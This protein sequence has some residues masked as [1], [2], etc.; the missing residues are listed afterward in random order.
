MFGP[1]FVIK[2]M[3]CPFQFGSHL[4]REEKAGCFTIILFLLP[5]VCICGRLGSMSLPRGTMIWSVS[6][7]NGIFPGH[8][9]FF[10][11]V[12]V[13]V[14][15]V[16]LLLFLLCVFCWV[17]RGVTSTAAPAANFSN[18]IGFWLLPGK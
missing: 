17:G 14:V 2:K 15:F 12:V 8:S 9:H 4:A 18:L 6:Y 1:G 16:V 10:V 3:L 5:S 11:I 13:V 7:K